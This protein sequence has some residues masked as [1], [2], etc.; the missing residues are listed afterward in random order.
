MLKEK[1]KQV[2]KKP[3]SYQMKDHRGKVIYVG[4]A[5][6]LRNRLLSYF[7]GSHDYKT[8]KMLS[9]VD[10]FD[11]IVTHTE[12]EAL[13]LELDLIKKHQPRYNVLLTDDKSYPYIEM[14]NEKHP[15]LIVTRRV[16]KK[17]R[18]RLFGPYPNVK[19]ARDTLRLLNK[20][21]PLRKCQRL[22]DEPCLYYHLGQCLGPCIK[23]VEQTT[24][25]EIEKKIRRFLKGH[26]KPVIDDLEEKMHAASDNLEFER[27]QEYKETIDAIKTTTQTK[28][29][30]HFNDS[31]SRDIIGI[32]TDAS[33]V[34]LSLV[35]VRHGRITAKDDRIMAYHGDPIDAVRDYLG[36]FYTTYPI[37][38]EI[39][40][41]AGESIKE[42]QS[43]FE[44]DIK[45]P[46]RGVKKKLL[47]LAV[48]NAGETLKNERQKAEQAE[49]KTFGVLEE[50]AETL[51]ID[52]PY[53]IEA[54]DNAHLFGSNAVSAVVVFENGRPSKHEYRKF[55]LEGESDVEQMKE[56][57]YRR[58]R[59]LLLEDAALPDLVLVDGGIQQ[60]NAARKVLDA[61]EVSVP[62]AGLVKGEDHRTSH[63][64]DENHGI[65]E[66]EK[67]SRLF[68]FLTSIQEEAHRFATTF[69]RNLREKGVFESVLD[70][71]EGVGPVRKKKLL[72]TFRTI[73]NIYEAPDEELRELGIPKTTIDAIKAHLDKTLQR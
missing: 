69:H 37:P 45:T 28:Q 27:A 25:R 36:Q 20:L 3:G 50:L 17:N 42:L 21:Y 4:K 41:N 49:K 34:A 38:R 22:P 62:L 32:A 8:T 39:F 35:F 73:E 58:Y 63:L 47:D 60:M 61:L 54:F 70:D 7:T 14:T 6:S 43:L 64:I 9:H 46:S 53:R 57:I 56:V 15:K 30:V 68:H 71:I 23:H 13:I 67:Q 33:Y 51:E 31:V 48:V 26:T 2:P 10:D 55:K 65:I 18:H 40:I 66:L 19:A 24:Y 16:K 59:R 52:V 29:A 12:L 11:Y 44:A 5:K 72:R 1:L